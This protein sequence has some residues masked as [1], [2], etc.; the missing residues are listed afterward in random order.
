MKSIIL[1]A[2]FLA[3]WCIYLNY[4]MGIL[5]REN[6]TLQGEKNALYETIKRYENAKTE[7]DKTIKRL[8][9]A[10][11]QDKDNLDW[12]NKRIP[13]DVVAVLQKQYND[14]RSN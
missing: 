2:V 12:Y 4:S 10:V 7:S 11:E 3:L 8:R 6:I 5:K 13:H 14:C 9:D 1:I